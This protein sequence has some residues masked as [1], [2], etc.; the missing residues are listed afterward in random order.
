[1]NKVMLIG[2]ITKDLELR[3]TG[4]GTSVLRFTLAVDRRVSSGQEKQADFINCVAWSR[5]AEVM[6]QYLHK[7]SRISVEGRIQ[8]GSYER[9]GQRVY[10]TDVIVE[11]FQFLDSKSASAPHGDYSAPA[12][13]YNEQSYDGNQGFEEDSFSMEAFDPSSEDLPF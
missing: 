1:M 6:C 4:S 2:R 12:V 7:G 9:E 11:N 10:T 8:T 3:K 5:S 13:D